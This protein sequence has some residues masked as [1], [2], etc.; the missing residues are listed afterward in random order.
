MYLSHRAGSKQDRKRRLALQYLL[1]DMSLCPT[2]E[3]AGISRE[4]V[5]H[6][7]L[8]TLLVLA[9]FAASLVQQPLGFRERTNSLS[10]LY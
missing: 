9:D 4:G 1:Q 6:S 2:R 10:W 7:Q 5:L 8:G 3:E